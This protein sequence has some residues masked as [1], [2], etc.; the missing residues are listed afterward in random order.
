MIHERITEQ[1][2]EASSSHHKCKQST[3]T[4]PGK[5]LVGGIFWTHEF[6]WLLDF[7]DV[8]E[9]LGDR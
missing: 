5:S 8:T 6:M 1:H 4:S 3:Y 2:G 7:D 9:L